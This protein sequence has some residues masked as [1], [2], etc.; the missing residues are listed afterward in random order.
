MTCK[1]C[2]PGDVDVDVTAEILEHEPHDPP[3]AQILPF[4]TS[5]QP[6]IMTPELLRDIKAAAVAR[7]LDVSDIQLVQMDC[8][9]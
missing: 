1:L 2:A 6:F 7:G 5:V 9:A 8:R 3:T 4:M